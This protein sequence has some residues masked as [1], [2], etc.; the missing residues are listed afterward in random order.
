MRLSFSGY[1]LSFPPSFIVFFVILT[2]NRY[3]FIMKLLTSKLQKQADAYTIEH[4]PILSINLMERAAGLMSEII[5]RHWDNSHRIIVFAGPGNNGGDALA[6]ARMLHLKGYPVE[7]FLFS[8]GKELSPDCAANANRLREVGCQQFSEIINAFNSPKLTD[9]DIIIDGLFG[10][11]LTKALEGGFASVVHYMNQSPASIVSVDVPSGLMC[12]DNS[13]N[14]RNAIVRAD[15][16]LTIHQPKLSFLFAENEEFVG[17]WVAIPIGTHSR[18][19]E[20]VNTPYHLLETSDVTSLIHPR[21][22]FAHKGNFGHALLIAGASGMAGAAVLAARA[23][24]RSGVGLLSVHVPKNSLSTIQTAVPEAMASIDFDERIF[25]SPLDLD[26]YQ[27]VG[28]GPGLGQDPVTE[29]A[30]L[31]QTSLCYMPLVLDAD[32][33]NIFSNYRSRMDDIPQK[34]ILTPH[35]KE[36]ERLVGNC[37]NSYERLIKAKDLSERLQSYVIL[38]GAWTVIITPEGQCYFNPTGN[39][40]MAK[41]GSGDVLT[42]ILTALLAQGYSPEDTCKLGVY[43]HGLAGDLAKEAKGEIG[44]TVQDIIDYLPNAW[45]HLTKTN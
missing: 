19:L 26:A 24:L 11:G 39:P 2:T 3:L 13:F 7:A 33:L 10:I 44:M 31:R 32:A 35:P 8:V 28:I 21:K 36:L 1:F 45:N 5:T 37:N 12:E 30:V 9:S 20:D 17:E 23:A 4:E 41:P 22:K 15:L 40:G 18:F 34:S 14:N 42:G 16:T 43:V 27:S 6:I 38:K 25:S 29:T